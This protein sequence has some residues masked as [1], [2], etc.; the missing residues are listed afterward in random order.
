MSTAA[1]LMREAALVGDRRAREWGARDQ[2]ALAGVDR[3]AA[4]E[5]GQGQRRPAVVGQGAELGVAGEGAGQPAAAVLDQIVAAEK[6]SAA[7]SPPEV[8]SATMV[9]FSVTKLLLL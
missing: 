5:Q 7:T 4:R 9:L 6:G 8:L 1:P 2:S 3:R